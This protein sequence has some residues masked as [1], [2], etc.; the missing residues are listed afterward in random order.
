MNL[1]S[2]KASELVEILQKKIAEHGDLEITV[3]TQDGGFYRLFNED[4]IQ[5]I[6]WT[7]T[8]DGTK[9]A[10]LEIG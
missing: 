1:K 8:K 6:E 3:N 10:T 9:T 7:N 4:C 2:L 5:K